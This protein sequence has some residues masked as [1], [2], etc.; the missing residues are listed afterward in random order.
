MCGLSQS[1]GRALALRCCCAGGLHRRVL[2]EQ[3]RHRGAP[4][5]EDRAGQI[6]SLSQ[7]PQHRLVVA[8]LVLANGSQLLRF[9]SCL[10]RQLP[11]WLARRAHGGS[12]L[13]FYHVAFQAGLVSSLAMHESG[14][15]VLY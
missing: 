11:P 3:P 9:H 7:G 6:K 5:T 10:S 8:L 13:Q 12:R 1:D 4:A 14:Q 2:H 15:N